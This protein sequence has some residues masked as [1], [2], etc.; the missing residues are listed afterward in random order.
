MS[1][2][3]D[4][5]KQA[6]VASSGLARARGRL[7]EYARLMRLDRPIGI[8]LLLWPALWALWISAD[9]HPDERIFVIGDTPWSSLS[10]YRVRDNKVEPLRHGHAVGWLFVA[11]VVLCLILVHFLMKPIGRGIR[12]MVGLEAAGDLLGEAIRDRVVRLG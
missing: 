7:V 9:G 11:G 8:W 10:E 1:D 2:L 6:A 3:T 5:D 12:R 4:L